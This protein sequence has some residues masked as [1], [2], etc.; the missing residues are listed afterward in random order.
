MASSSSSSSSLSTNTRSH[1]RPNSAP[2]FLLPLSFLSSLL[3]IASPLAYLLSLHNSLPLVHATHKEDYGSQNPTAAAGRRT[4]SSSADG[5]VVLPLKLTFTAPAKYWTDAI[6]IGN[7]RLGAAVWGG[8]ANETLQLNDD[9]LWTGVPGTYSDPNAPAALSVVRK[10]VSS[11]LYPEASAEAIK[12]S[13][14][15]SQRYQLL[16][17]IVLEFDAAHQNYDPETYIRELDLDTAMATVKYSVGDVDYTREHFATNPHQAIVTRISGSKPGSLSFT[18]H[19]HSKLNHTTALIQGRRNQIVLKGSCR[20]HPKGIQFTA[21]LELKIEGGGKAAVRVLDGGKK[22][23]VDFADSAVLILVASSSFDGPF[24]SPVDSK[25][26]PDSDC[27]KALSSLANVAYEDLRARH[28]EDYQSLFRRVSLQLSRGTNSGSRVV[29]TAERVKSFQTDEDPSLVALMFQYGRYLLISCSRPGTQV[30]NLQGIWNE[31][32]NPPW[33][34]AQHLNINLQMNYWSAL[35]CNLQECQEPLFDY[36]S[37]L[38]VNGKETAKVNYGVNNGW[39]AHQVSDI[40]AKTSPDQGDA[41]WAMWPMGGAW[42]CTH[43]WEH[44]SYTM[45][46]DFLGKKGYPLLEGCTEFLLG[47]LVEGQGGNL[48]TNPSTSPEHKFIDPEGGKQASVSNSTTM[49]MS[50]ITQVFSDILSA[51]EVLG[52]QDD[53]LIQKVRRARARLPPTKV[54]KDG[55][56]MEWASEFEDPDPQHRHVSHLFGLFPGRAITPQHTPQLCSASEKTLVKRGVEG[57]GWST[58]WKAALWARLQKSGKA[59]EMVKHLFNLVDPT[60]ERDNEG[61]VFSNLFAAH[62]PFQIDANLGFS[63]VIAEMLV[64]GTGT[65]LYLLPALPRDKWPNGCAKGLRARG[66]LTVNLCWKQGQ[67]H[68]VGVWSTVGDSVQ[69]LHYGEKMVKASIA[70]CNVYIFNSDLTCVR[71]ESLSGEGGSCLKRLKW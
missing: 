8:V 16:G 66:G 29:S 64:Q 2:S 6:P 7:G 45:D 37:S 24:T 4:D 23:K 44:Y 51:A 56:I 10:L 30:A 49:D 28:L 55:T 34:G 42:L 70:S 38:A 5:G 36:M 52:R 21:T 46:K 27:R 25:K 53:E 32:V 62:P 18:V 63:A 69:V 22:L 54:A 19:L 71:T 17:D 60:Y 47:W 48:E 26:D 41:V 40:W 11:G 67:L 1:H 14:T 33:E 20:G 58:V 65:E 31:D 39:V 50:I 57:P 68:E 59:Y 3:L 13:G 61:G 35:S 12:L 43:L 15:P 9:T